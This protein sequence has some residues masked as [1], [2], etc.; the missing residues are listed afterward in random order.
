M[1][2]TVLETDITK[3]KKFQ[4]KI[5]VENYGLHINSPKGEAD[6]N[7]TADIEL[8]REEA[9]KLYKAMRDYLVKN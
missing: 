4:M 1:T 2:D 7:G 6:L 3:G 5:Q 9:M 8:D